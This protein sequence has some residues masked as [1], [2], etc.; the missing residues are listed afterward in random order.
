MRQIS[1]SVV[2][3]GSMIPSVVAC[4]IRDAVDLVARGQTA[5]EIGLWVGLSLVVGG[6]RR[7]SLLCGQSVG[8]IVRAPRLL[9]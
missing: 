4:L 7:G 6:L 3:V 5:A 1:L 8:V 2:L 9:V